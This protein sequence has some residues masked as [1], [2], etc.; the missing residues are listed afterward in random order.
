M[1]ETNAMIFS[2]HMYNFAFEFVK[3]DKK[4]VPFEV[5]ENIAE[6]SAELKTDIY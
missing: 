2:E 4:F 1:R 6:L 5:P 3:F